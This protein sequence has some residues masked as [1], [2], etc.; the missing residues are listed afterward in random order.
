MGDW[1]WEYGDP[2]GTITEGEADGVTMKVGHTLVVV[3]PGIRN[4]ENKTCGLR[5][6]GDERP[7]FRACVPNHQHFKSN[8]DHI[9]SR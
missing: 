4:F 9:N 6:D 3:Y 1:R 5:I 7:T 8:L 2:S